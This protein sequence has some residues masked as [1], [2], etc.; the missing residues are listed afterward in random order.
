V[1]LIFKGALIMPVA[2]SSDE[3][4]LV[5]RIRLGLVFLFARLS[6]ANN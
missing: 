2:P 4:G 1:K 5:S 6:D 3:F